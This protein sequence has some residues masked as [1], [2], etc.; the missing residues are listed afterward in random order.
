MG[1]TELYLVDN[2]KLL[3]R[4]KNDDDFYY[5]FAKQPKLTKYTADYVYERLSLLKEKISILLQ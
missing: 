3:K 5:K 4:L 2:I 1:F